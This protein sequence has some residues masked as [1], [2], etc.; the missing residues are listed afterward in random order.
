[1]NCALV[2]LPFNEHTM[3]PL[4]IANLV[5]FLRKNGKKAEAVDL[6]IALF[7]RF[8]SLYRSHSSFADDE[9]LPWSENTLFQQAAAE[10]AFPERVRPIAY[11]QWKHLH[12]PWVIEDFLRFSSERLAGRYGLVGISVTNVS[13]FMAVALSR[14][15]KR[16]S[17]D[18]LLVWGGPSIRPD[19]SLGPFRDLDFV[20]LFVYGAGE[21]PLNE[22]L[23]RLSGQG[24]VKPEGLQGIPGTIW[25]NGC[26][27]RVEARPRSEGP[28]ASQPDFSDFPLASY[29]E[30]RL[31]VRTAAGCAWSKCAFCA[32]PGMLESYLPRPLEDVAGELQLSVKKQG[33]VPYFF[34]DNC[35]NVDPERLHRLCGELRSIGDLSWTCMVRS[36]GLDEELM[37][38]MHAAG[39]RGLFIGLESFSDEVLCAMN[40][41][42]TRLD[43]LKAFRL[44]RETGIPMMG[45]FLI[46][47]PTEKASDI[48][49]T[50]LILKRY[51]HLWI[52]C[53]FWLSPFSVTPGSRVH[54]NPGEYGVR[55]LEWSDE[56]RDLPGALSDCVPAWNLNWLPVQETSPAAIEKCGL[57]RELE[58][59]LDIV[60]TRELPD[61]FV[62]EGTNGLSVHS[63]NESRTKTTEVCLSDGEAGILRFCRDIR[64]ME[65]LR[66]EARMEMG[67]LE[68]ELSEMENRGWVAVSG[69]Q[70][71]TTVPWLAAR[72]G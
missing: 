68:K 34:V 48:R 17:E 72:V 1:M 39:C 9:S 13:F 16:S 45:N 60:H 24:G 33:R 15:L 57:Y 71:L 64:E 30:L 51:T 27:L 25:K 50:I 37:R 65:A 49:E 55:V 22:I 36:R 66:R 31:P 59:I 18:L 67:S 23:E 10:R 4:G 41:G 12:V 54:E 7:D 8:R 5:G 58:R 62:V 28:E 46:A 43:H 47:F 19:Q 35:L 6:N 21:R 20:D 56:T 70:V 26:D 32:E 52:G 11:P 2:W 3:P 42:C 29:E 63:E 38:A 53:R 14:M 44:A 61:Q 69:T 40:K